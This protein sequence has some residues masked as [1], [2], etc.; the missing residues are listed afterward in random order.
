MSDNNTFNWSFGQSADVLRLNLAGQCSDD[1]VDLGWFCR[2]KTFNKREAR[3]MIE[4]LNV[5]HDAKRRKIVSI[6][7]ISFL[8]LLPDFKS[9]SR[10]L[11]CQTEPFV[12]HI[13]QFAAGTNLLISLLDEKGVFAYKT[14]A[15]CYYKVNDVFYALD[16]KGNVADA[17]TRTIFEVNGLMTASHIMRKI[18]PTCTFNG[19]GSQ[20]DFKRLQ[21]RPEEG[22]GDNEINETLPAK[23]DETPAA[24]QWQYGQDGKTLVWALQKFGIMVRMH[25]EKLMLDVEAISD[26]SIFTKEQ[27]LYLWS[28]V[29]VV[30]DHR[31]QLYIPL[32]ILISF[33]SFGT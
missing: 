6:G 8:Y 32:G 23:L 11:F 27:A 12:A 25:K 1:T 9:W 4:D 29:K 10:A 30:E 2:N 21:Q 17:D 3:T 20:T 15:A 31:R 14:E 13:N 5:M 16:L 7:T 33:C 28:T 26:F 19:T 22:D 24:L 18:I